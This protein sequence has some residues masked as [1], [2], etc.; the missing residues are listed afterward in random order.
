[1][2]TQTK[3]HQCGGC[4]IRWGGFN[5]AHC[6]ICHETFGVPANFDKHRKGDLDHRVCVDPTSVGLHMDDRGVWVKLD[7]REW[8]DRTEV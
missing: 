5:T 8:D 2:A 4:D 1:M 3:P 6:K 7:M